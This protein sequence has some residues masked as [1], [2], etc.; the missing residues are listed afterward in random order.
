MVSNVTSSWRV[1]ESYHS[2]HICR[3]L[4]ILMGNILFI[5]YGGAFFFFAYNKG[6]LADTLMQSI[7]HFQI[8]FYKNKLQQQQK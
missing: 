2:I 3:K 6:W 4:S 7:I 1:R 8:F 5:L